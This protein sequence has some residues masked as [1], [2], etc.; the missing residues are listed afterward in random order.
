MLHRSNL[1]L[2][3]IGPH[4]SKGARGS[5]GVGAGVVAGAVLG[6]AAGHVNR[7]SAA[8]VGRP[9]ALIAAS[10]PSRAA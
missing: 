8:E 1:L 4:D 9:D 3:P 7:G 6:L 5:G 10:P 2:R